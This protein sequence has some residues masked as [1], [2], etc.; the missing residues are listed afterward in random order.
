MGCSKTSKKN[1]QKQLFKLLID[2]TYC[3]RNYILLNYMTNFI[4][5]FMKYLKRV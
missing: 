5:D 1:L 2:F 4:K 3:L